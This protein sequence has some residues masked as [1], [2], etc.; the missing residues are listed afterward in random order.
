[1]CCHCTTLKSVAEFDFTTA[2]SS[3]RTV[4]YGIDRTNKNT[5]VKRSLGACTQTFRDQN[6]SH[7]LDWIV[8]LGRVDCQGHM[9]PQNLAQ[10]RR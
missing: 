8:V 10:K 6:A 7:G 2:D 1:M 3:P 9:R 5:N 4:C